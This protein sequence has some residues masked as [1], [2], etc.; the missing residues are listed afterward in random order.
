MDSSQEQRMQSIGVETIDW[1][2]EP[3]GNSSLS[4]SH[5]T[6]SWN[7]K[8]I[9]L[10]IALFIVAGIFEVGGGY[11]VWIGLRDKKSPWVCIPIGAVVLVAY[12]LIPTFQPV[13]S[14]GRIYAVYGGFFVVLSYAWSVVFD[15]FQ[16]DWGDYLGGAIALFG[17]CVAWF[18]PR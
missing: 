8:T 10:S 1:L 16:L 6:A 15:G 17:V 13:D 12:G 7:W 2:V 4:S 18:W 14:F 11:L 5:G 3:C 9:T